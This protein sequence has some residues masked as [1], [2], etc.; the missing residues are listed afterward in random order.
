MTRGGLIYNVCGE[1][2][3]LF[4]EIN[5]KKKGKLLYIGQIWDEVI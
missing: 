3:S 2:M 4:W 5:F 1:K